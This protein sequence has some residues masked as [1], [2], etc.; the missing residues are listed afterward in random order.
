MRAAPPPVS[1]LP[2][3]YADAPVEASCRDADASP[4]PGQDPLSI[5]ERARL[6]RNRIADLHQRVQGAQ[7]RA[8]AL[9]HETATLLLAA[10]QIQRGRT[11]KELLARSEHARLRARMQTM[12]VI[13]QAKGILMA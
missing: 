11:R 1:V 10:E 5:I 9:M 12:P 2:G 8:A 6:T 13:E 7:Q 4:S 3:R